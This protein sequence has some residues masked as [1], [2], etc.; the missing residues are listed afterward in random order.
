MATTVSLDELEFAM[1][2]VSAGHDIEAYVS[3]ST[4]R[5][6]VGGVDGLVDEDFPEDTDDPDLVA[7]PSKRDLDLGSRLARRFGRELAPH[8]HDEIEACFRRKGAYGCFRALLVRT[9]LVDLW[10]AFE[11]AQTR[12]AL[13]AW[14]ED[15][16]FEI[17]PR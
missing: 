7:V 17:V 15:E 9:N 13:T 14:A 10:Y 6:Y 12:R 16:G 1:N 5:V 3:R 8:V 11:A 4:G 2:G